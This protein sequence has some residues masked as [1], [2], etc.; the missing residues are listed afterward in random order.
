[1]AIQHGADIISQN[2]LR[3]FNNFKV[4]LMFEFLSRLL[5]RLSRVKTALIHFPVEDTRQGSG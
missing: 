3:L 5:S 4:R 2:L 1:M